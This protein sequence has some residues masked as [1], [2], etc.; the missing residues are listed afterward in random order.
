MKSLLIFAALAGL[1]AHSARE[2]VEGPDHPRRDK[3]TKP[4]RKN[5]FELTD[6]EVEFMSMMT[7]KEKKK[8]LKGKK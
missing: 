4:Q 5:K 3:R 2:F 1:S 8:F 6:E 7:P